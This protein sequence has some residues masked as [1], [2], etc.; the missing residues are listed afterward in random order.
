MDL[1]DF[2]ECYLNILLEKLSKENKTAFLLGDFNIDLLKYDKHNSTNEFLDT[3]SSNY[4]LP[5]ILLP[6]RITVSSKTLIDNIFTNKISQDV[7]SGNISASISDHLPQFSIIADIFSNKPFPKSN[8]FE[9]DWSNFDQQNFVLDFFS[10]DW[11][12]NLNLENKDINGSFTSFLDTMNQILDRYAPYKKLSKYQLKFKNKPWLSKGLQK[13]IQIKNVFFKKYIRAKDEATKVKF[14]DKY[15]EYRNLLSTLMKK[16]KENYYNNFFQTNLKNIRNTWKG[17][18]SLISNS[19]YGPFV[20]QNIYSN[21]TQRTDPKNIVNAFNDYFCTVAI[22]IQSSIRFSFKSYEDYLSNSNVK[23][24]FI[25]PTDSIE[26]FDIISNLS[27]EKSQGPNGIPMKVL[28]LLNND[29]SPLLADPFNKSFTSGIFPSALK[30]ARI[31][32]IHKIDSKLEC[33]NYRPISILSNLDKIFEKLMYKRL[34]SFL[35]A[36]NII[37]NLQFGF[38]KSYSTTLA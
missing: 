12:H 9:R 23:S 30:I 6:T 11:K 32:T 22:Y 7:I 17:I 35:E 13:S 18:K 38:R 19:D 29:F 33:G 15:K 10:I 28:R 27:T 3:L 20:P 5:L 8:V 14:H 4:F 25:S 34:Y 21:G 1:E 36:N 24:F 2:N 16:S 26:I 37:Y 31:I